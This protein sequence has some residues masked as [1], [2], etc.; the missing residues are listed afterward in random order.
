MAAAGGAALAVVQ[1]NIAVFTA[2]LTAFISGMLILQA[3]ATVYRRVERRILEPAGLLRSL[4]GPWLLMVLLGTVLLSLPLATHSAVPDYRH[5]FWDHI[6]NNAFASVSSAC[7]VGT[8]VYDLGE[9]YSLFGQIVLVVITQLAGLGLAAVGLAILQP[10]MSKIIRLRTVL[11]SAVGLQAAAVG[12]MWTAWSP[13]DVSSAGQRAWWGIVHA[14]SAMWNSG[15]TLRSDGLAAYVSSGPVFATVTTLCIVGSLGLPVIL[16]LV[17]GRRATKATVSKDPKSE[18]PAPWRALPQWEATAAFLL[19]LTGAVALFVFETPWREEIAWQ[20]PDAWV[21]ERPVD[22]GSNR[23]ALG[24]DM[25]HRARWSRALFVSATLRSAGMGSIPVSRGALSW[26]SYGL[27][28]LGMFVGGSAGGVAGGLRTSGLVLLGICLLKGRDSWNSLPGGAA[29]RRTILLGSVLFLPLWLVLN[30]ASIGLLALAS[31]GTGYEVVL[32][33]TAACNSVG[34]ATGLA[35]HLTWAGRLSMIVI[36]V[37]GRVVPV[38]YWLA[39][40]RRFGRCLRVGEG[41]RMSRA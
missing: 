6:L 18:R 23:I 17:F 39:L 40:S 8:T 41:S 16:D 37:G 9:D 31:G 10:F 28:C 21:P 15:L 20:L 13:S 5:N 29:A 33:G 27:L 26:P 35:L 7:L 4:A 1:G 36:M 12:A 24:D 11:L 32:D 22:L 34:L 2:T 30:G 19:L 3:L 25:P 14:G 38:A